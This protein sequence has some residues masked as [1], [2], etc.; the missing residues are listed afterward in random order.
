M[1]ESDNSTKPHCLCNLF[2][3]SV[4]S[5]CPLT[6]Y[7]PTDRENQPAGIFPAGWCCLA[8]FVFCPRPL[9]FSSHLSSHLSDQDRQHSSS[10]SAMDTF[11][12][13]GQAARLS[14]RF[15]RADAGTL[16]LSHSA[17]G[18]RRGSRDTGD[19]GL[20][21]NTFLISGRQPEYQLVLPSDRS[22]RTPDT[23]EYLP[24]THRRSWR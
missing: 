16:P 2:L 11:D 15:E 5:V 20:I 19:D 4:M 23:F 12:F 21:S 3:L 9:L 10:I 24:K 14:C 22:F 6:T 18:R 17:D 13:D 7:L 1:K 8:C